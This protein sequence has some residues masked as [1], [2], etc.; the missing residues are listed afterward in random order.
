ML[1]VR[2]SSQSHRVAAPVATAA[3]S[4]VDDERGDSDEFE[5]ERLGIRRG[6]VGTTRTERWS[7]STARAWTCDGEDDVDVGAD[8]QLTTIRHAIDG[9]SSGEEID[10]RSKDR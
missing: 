9:N 7:A 6:R 1:S 5:I 2:P 3:A 8:V 10:R 4:V